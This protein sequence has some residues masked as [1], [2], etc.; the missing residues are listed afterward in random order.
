MSEALSSEAIKENGIGASVRRREDHRFITGEGQYTDDLNQPGQT[1]GVFCRS[2]YARARINGIDT[3]EALAVEGVLA[4]YTGAEMVADGLGDL[5]CGWLVK[6]KDGEDM[7]SS[8]NRREE[9]SYVT[10]ERR[11][12]IAKQRLRHPNTF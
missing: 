9:K 10:A 12:L 8:R 6:S 2:P 3:S 1:Y 4:V 7:K 11:T 5:P